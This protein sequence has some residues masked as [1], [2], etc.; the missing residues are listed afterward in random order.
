MPLPHVKIVDFTLFI[1][2]FDEHQAEFFAKK[3][4]YRLVLTEADDCRTFRTDAI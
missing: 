1:L 2:C 4:I 3:K